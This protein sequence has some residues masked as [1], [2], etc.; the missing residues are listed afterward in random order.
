MKKVEE[1]INN[2]NKLMKLIPKNQKIIIKLTTL[3]I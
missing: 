2:E 1:I 3:I